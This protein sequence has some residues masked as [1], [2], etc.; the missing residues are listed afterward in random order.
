LFL[1][2]ESLKGESLEKLWKMLSGDEKMH[3]TCR[4][5][6]I[7]NGMHS[8]PSPGFYSAKFKLEK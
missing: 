8:L 1:V 7:F 2:V 6:V 5:K 4:L 3:I